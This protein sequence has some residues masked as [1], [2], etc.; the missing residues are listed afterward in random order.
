VRCQIWSAICA[1]LMVALVRKELN[2]QKSLNEILQIVSV[3]IFEQIPLAE[4][5]ATEP[6]I[7]ERKFGDE[8]SQKLLCLN[9]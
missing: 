5:F 3:N 4:L 8:Q 6:E 1:Y 2:L 9:G 7:A